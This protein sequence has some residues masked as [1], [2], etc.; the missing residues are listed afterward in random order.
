[1][2]KVQETIPPQ[3]KSF[4]KEQKFALAIL[5][6]EL[7]HGMSGQEI[8]D[9]LYR[10]ARETGLDGKQVFETVYLALLGLKSGP[11]AGHFL[12]SLEKD[13]IVKRFKEASL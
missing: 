1:K 3:V 4:T 9:N 12:A 10:I 5:A 2:F 7:E 6:D 13:F 8:H 11:R